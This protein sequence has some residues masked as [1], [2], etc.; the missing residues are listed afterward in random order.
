MW[1]I[2]LATELIGTMN[3]ALSILNKIPTHPIFYL[4]K[5]DHNP[6]P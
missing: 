1:E 6:K 4:L 2:P 5:G 3:M